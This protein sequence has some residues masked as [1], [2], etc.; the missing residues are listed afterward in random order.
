MKIQLTVCL[1]NFLFLF[2]LMLCSC[3]VGITLI[4]RIINHRNVSVLMLN[5][6]M[7]KF[8]EDDNKSAHINTSKDGVEI[9]T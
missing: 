1:V 5:G 6:S 4:I 9:K 7:W 2:Q 8:V 3:C